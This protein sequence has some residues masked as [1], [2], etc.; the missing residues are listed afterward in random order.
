MDLMDKLVLEDLT[1]EQ[2]QMAELIGLENYKK[3]VHVFGGSSVY[4]FKEST[5]IKTLRD[6]EIKDKF[7]GRNITELA[8]MYDLS[9]KQV[10]NILNG[11]DAVDS[12]QLYITDFLNG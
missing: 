2:R 5:L 7:N 3:L 10:R 8:K 11:V 1:E 6:K 4:I 9:T 12:G